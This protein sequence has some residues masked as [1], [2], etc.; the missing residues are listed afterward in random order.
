M[1]LRKL[2]ENLNIIQALP[3]KPTNTATELK[4]QFDLS[5]NKIKEYINEI[6]TEDLDTVLASKADNDNVYNKITIDTLLQAKADST[7]ISLLIKTEDVKITVISNVRIGGNRGAFTLP[8][9]YKVLTANIVTVDTPVVASI[10]SIESYINSSYV[11]ITT[12]GA[13]GG[14]EAKVTVRMIYIKE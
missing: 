3:D 1:G 14:Y 5:G 9:G 6:L 10:Q 4:Q 8:T 2:L 7:D 13:T 12:L 11:D